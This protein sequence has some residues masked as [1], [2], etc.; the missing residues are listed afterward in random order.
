[1]PRTNPG[2]TP[3]HSS[4][5][6]YTSLLRAAKRKYRPDKPTLISSQRGA[7][8][9]LLLTIPHL[10]TE[11]AYDIPYIN[12]YKHLLDVLPKHTKLTILVNKGMIPTVKRW[13]ADRSMISRTQLVESA[14][15]LHF[16]VWAEDAYAIVKDRS[17]GQHYF[18]EPLSFHRYGDSLVA[19]I[20]DASTNFNATQTP[21]Y[22]QGGN[23]LIG[24]DYFFIGIDYPA[25]TLKYVGDVLKK[26]TDED[27]DA[28]VRRLYHEYLDID[29]ELVYIGSMAPHPRPELRLTKMFGEQWIELVH[30]SVG[31]SQPIFHI[32]MFISL[33]GNNPTTGKQRVLVGDPA[34]AAK[35][36]DMSL[37]DDALAP[38]FDDIANQLTKLDFEVTRNPLPYVYVD[39]MGEAAWSLDYIQS[40][41]DDNIKGAE[42]VR[43]HMLSNKL[44]QIPARTWYYATANNC[45]TESISDGKSNT[46]WLPSY[47]HDTWDILSVT[48]SINRRLWDDLGYK[49]IDLGDFHH[50]ASQFG[51]AHCITKYLERQDS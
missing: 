34:F 47:G 40:F 37:P 44:K 27:H 12:T 35:L 21:I 26:P 4:L 13:L 41:V 22:F 30:Y 18:V 14:D 31:K 11:N 36:I 8:T 16:S 17:D 23:I 19:D 51:A 43:Q 3:P 25:K 1:M 38:S 6:R 48:D 32:D 20:I 24:D 7:I 2:V 45:L 9:R 5:S 29:R 28:F 33:A 50:Y 46:V 42:T 49:V 15:H 10:D 39:D